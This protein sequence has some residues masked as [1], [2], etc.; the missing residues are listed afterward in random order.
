M[1]LSQHEIH[2]YQEN[3]FSSLKNFIFNTTKKLKKISEIILL[4]N[5]IH[6]EH[7]LIISKCLTIF[8][9]KNKSHYEAILKIF[10]LFNIIQ[11]GFCD[12]KLSLYLTEICQKLVGIF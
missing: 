1:I 3:E 6:T 2:Y 10:S 7:S 9:N 4:V 8:Q 11:K 5:Q 12:E